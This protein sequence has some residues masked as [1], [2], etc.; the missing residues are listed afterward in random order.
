[1]KYKRP[2]IIAF[3]AIVVIGGGYLALHKPQSTTLSTSS[4][5]TNGTT[6]IVNKP[7][8]DFTV[9][10]IDGQQF[11]LAAHKGK[12]VIVFAMLVA[13]ASAYQWVKRSI[14]FKKILPVKA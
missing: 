8:P 14:K 10:T 9:Q 5:L 3:A 7:A 4:Q 12:P 13:V 2:L 11:S 1:M 6:A